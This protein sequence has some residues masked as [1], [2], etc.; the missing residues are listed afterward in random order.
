MGMVK[1]VKK[2]KANIW[3]VISEVAREG[4][5]ITVDSTPETHKGGLAQVAAEDIGSS[6]P[7]FR[8]AHEAH[9]KLMKPVKKD[10]VS[11]V[12]E[13]QILPEPVYPSRPW[14]K[15][16][17]NKLAYHLATGWRGFRCWVVPYV[18]SRLH[19]NNLRPMLSYLF[20]DYKC[21]LDC[22]Y[23]WAFDNKV[24]GMTEDVAKR[25]IDW[26][27]SIGCRVIAIMGGEP[28]IRPKFIHKIVYYGTKRG[29]FVYVPTNGRLMTPD[30]IDRLGDAGV[31]AFN[32]A[33]DCLDEKPGLPKALNLIRP[34]FEYLVKKQ[35]KYGYM[36]SFNIN[37]CHNNMDD[38]RELT[39]LAYANACSTD[40]HIN[41][42]PLMQ[43]DHFQHLSNNPTY[44]RP[45]DY[46][47]VDELID[48]LIDC[49][50]RGYMMVNPLSYFK[51][52]KRFMR[53]QLDSW[54]CRAGL[55][56]MV[57]RTDGTLAPCFAMYSAKH[58]WGVLEKQKFEVGHLTEMKKNCS[59][60]CMSTCNWTIAHH[61]N[62]YRVIWLAIKQL[63]HGHQ[64]VRAIS[65]LD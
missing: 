29:F 43:H 46:P 16:G 26:L 3:Q 37:I 14:L 65:Q 13:P 61:Y 12:G 21:N 62:D 6:A 32:L 4:T 50:R 35:Q 56:T 22:Y 18:G 2:E 49:S 34:Q 23:C 45:E 63:M 36:I 7:P 40:Y 5:E 33:V 51:S 8:L 31:A 15:E 42:P 27:H 30:I 1:M 20:T 47:K 59:P 28:L 60:H 11:P 54:P 64:G 58:D 24:Q 39:E 19:P 17:K 48:H 53:G 55:N 57:I 44:I 41:E 10:L 9:E 25:S 52:M 38:V